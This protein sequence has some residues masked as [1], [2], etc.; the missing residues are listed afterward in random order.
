MTAAFL[1][2]VEREFKVGIDALWDAWASPT[3]LEQW[4][5]PTDLAVLPGSVEN[6]TRVGGVWAAAVDV[7][8]HNFVAYF[9]GV[10]TVVEP[11]KRLEH[12]M[13]YTQDSAEFAAR[14]EG[15]SH[16]VVVE[17][18]DRGESSWVKFSQFG[19]LPEGQAPQAQAG[20]ESY[21]NNLGAYLAR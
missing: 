3:A 17:F 19:E 10:Y 8:A 16:L 2:S 7:A 9:Y 14:Q 21:F 11:L 4:Y 12:T 6:D 18:E 1:Y 20:M 5:C 15:P 13:I